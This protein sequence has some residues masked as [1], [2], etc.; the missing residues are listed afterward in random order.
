ML[1]E[2][3]GADGKTWRAYLSTTGPTG[4]NARDRI[5]SG[6]WY[7]SNGVEIASS[8]SNLLG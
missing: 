5:G 4:V 8:V 1:A 6:P 2:A 7:N 3:A